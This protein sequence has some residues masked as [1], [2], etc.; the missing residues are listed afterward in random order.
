MIQ[1]QVQNKFKTKVTVC[2]LVH[3]FEIPRLLRTDASRSSWCDE[4]KSLDEK[5]TLLIDRR[6]FD[7]LQLAQQCA[8]VRVP[9]L[10]SQGSGADDRPV[11]KLHV[12][13]LTG[14]ENLTTLLQ[15]NH[16][17]DERRI[18]PR[19]SDAA[20]LLKRDAAL[21]TVAIPE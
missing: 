9:E 8:G 6:R 20:R 21:L 16:L 4:A 5:D 13:R 12:V 1:G 11:V 10:D 7:A 14:R 17:V 3:A 2:L 19:C 18:F 15:F